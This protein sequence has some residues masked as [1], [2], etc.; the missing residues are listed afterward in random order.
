MPCA[1]KEQRCVAS[2]AS[3]LLSGLILQPAWFDI[4]RVCVTVRECMREGVC[5]CVWMRVRKR[6]EIACVC[7]NV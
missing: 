2:P 6:Y 1:A 5:V 4:N 7:L 3:L